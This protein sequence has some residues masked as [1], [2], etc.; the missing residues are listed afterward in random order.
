MEVH[1]ACFDNSLRKPLSE[2]KRQLTMIRAPFTKQ[3]LAGRHDAIQGE[4]SMASLDLDAKDIAFSVLGSNVW[5]RKTIA[6]FDSLIA[7][8]GPDTV[9]HDLRDDPRRKLQTNI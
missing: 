2:L 3:E 5:M 6:E 9:L 1:K 7:S 8:I 4:A